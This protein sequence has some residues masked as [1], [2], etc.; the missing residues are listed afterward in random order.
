MNE[1]KDLIEG[2]RAP[3]DTDK[4]REGGMTY[5]KEKYRS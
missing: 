4:L 5:G 2:I 1:I 3:Q